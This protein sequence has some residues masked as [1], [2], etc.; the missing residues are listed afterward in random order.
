MHEVS[1]LN[2]KELRKL[3]GDRRKEFRVGSVGAE[4]AKSEG[5]RAVT[6]TSMKIK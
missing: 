3:M 4:C 2:I 6:P 1:G 5:R